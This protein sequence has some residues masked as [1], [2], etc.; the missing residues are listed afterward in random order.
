MQIASLSVIPTG[1]QAEIP[2]IG[3]P[4]FLSKFPEDLRSCLTHEVSIDYSYPFGKETIYPRWSAWGVCLKQCL[5]RMGLR[6]SP[7][8]FVTESMGLPLAILSAG[9][10]APK[11][12][13]RKIPLMGRKRQVACDVIQGVVSDFD[14]KF[15]KLARRIPLLPHDINAARLL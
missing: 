5:S 12:I 1:V 8:T 10:P 14:S 9:V 13:V 15:E 11:I 3:V 4:G 2:V 6:D 7:V